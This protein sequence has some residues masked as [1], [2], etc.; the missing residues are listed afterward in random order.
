MDGFA[1][2]PQALVEQYLD[3]GLWSREETISG[4]LARNARERGDHD[5]IVDDQGTRLTYAELDDAATRL[6]ASLQARGVGAG[7]VV[8]VQL[9]NRAE[10]SV[11]ACAVAR[12][13]GVLNPLVPMYRDHEVAFASAA[14]RM[15]ALIVPG[16]HRSFDHDALALRVAA[17]VPSISTIVTLSDDAPAGTESLAS[18]LRTAPEL[19]PVTH[20]P[21]AVAAVLF[22]SGTESDPKGALHTT[23][24]LLAN[25][26]GLARLLDL[27]PDDHVFMGSPVGHGTGFGFGVLLSLWLG[28][29]LVLQ[30]HWSAPEAATMMAEERC[31]YTHA[32]MPFAH[33]L[34]HV[35][36]LTERDLSSLRHFVSG[37]ASVPRG[38]VA[39]IR[40]SL[41]A[42]LL[43]L[44]GQTEAFMTTINRP[45]DPLETLESRDGCPAPGVELRIHG[46]DGAELPRDT[47]GEAVCRG[48]HR[49]AGF[50][51][52]PVRTEATFGPGGW[53]RMG[54]YCTM[55]AA[56]YI[57]VVGRKKEVINRGGYKYSPR[58]VEDLLQVHPDILRVAI[59]RMADARLGEKA[60]AFIVAREGAE[61]TLEAVVAH[62]RGNGVAAFKWPERLEL[63]GELP[64]T[65]S[66]KVQKFVLEQRLA[67]PVAG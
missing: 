16:A 45:H 8:G 9:P 65:A 10:A 34:M 66:G 19:D 17:R 42:T 37:G 27:G 1:P 48:P 57:T 21:D 60:C 61:L 32:S 11:V 63:V 3:E 4:L 6:A 59:V 2:V 5:A 20:D 7:D 55:D 25:C 29:K 28:S 36:G 12:L 33:D 40:E 18:L 46:D 64:M 26:R 14:C 54:D 35:P 22:T 44:Y 53:M 50:L 38:F 51:D 31:V 15:K 49:C 39:R 43:R 13:G 56:G 52:D 62:L 23:N 41:G 58:E 47:P 67:A 30:T 24:T